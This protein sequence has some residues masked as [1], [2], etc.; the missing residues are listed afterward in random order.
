HRADLSGPRD[1]VAP[2][3]ALALASVRLAAPV[4]LV[5]ICLEGAAQSGL[6]WAP[7]L[8]ATPVL[9]LSALWLHRSL[10]Q[11]AEPVRRSRIVQVVSAG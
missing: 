7:V 8:L 11:Y 6:W 4:G 1:A 5:A 2:P 9:V 3:G 10:D